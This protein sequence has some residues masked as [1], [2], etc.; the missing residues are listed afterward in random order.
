MADTQ[1]LRQEVEAKVPQDKL[2]AINA[3]IGPLDFFR[4][5]FYLRGNAL[6]LHNLSYLRSDRIHAPDAYVV[7]QVADLQPLESLGKVQIIAKSQRPKK[8]NVPPLALFH[9]EFA[10]TSS[11]F[12][13][14]K[15]PRCRR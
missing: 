9:L 5:Q 1:F 8:V 6:L 7:G 11:V 14:R 3:A 4:V 12:P 13:H 10:R 2:L 15:F